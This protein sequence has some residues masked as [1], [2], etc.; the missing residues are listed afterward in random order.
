[1]IALL[2][3]AVLDVVAFLIEQINTSFVCLFVFGGLLFLFVFNMV[4][5]V[6]LVS[7]FFIITIKR[8]NQNQF[9]S[10]GIDSNTYFWFSQKTM[11]ILLFSIIILCEGTRKTWTDE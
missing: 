3:T 9:N 1:M 6:I 10:P 11:L 8:K 2:A 7:I 4:M 5:A